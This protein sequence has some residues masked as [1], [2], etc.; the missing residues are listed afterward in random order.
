M[1]PVCWNGFGSPPA[2]QII[3]M[4]YETMGPNWIAAHRA[5]AQPGILF[6]FHSCHG[7]PKLSCLPPFGDPAPSAFEKRSG[8]RGDGEEQQQLKHH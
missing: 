1:Y 4:Q 8:K 6:R 2:G 5:A 3:G 7:S